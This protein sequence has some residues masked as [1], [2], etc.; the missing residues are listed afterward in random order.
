MW[1]EPT[2]IASNAGFPGGIAVRAGDSLELSLFVYVGT[3]SARIEAKLVDGMGTAGRI[4]G[5]TVIVHEAPVHP[6][7]VQ[8]RATL[9]VTMS[10]GS[11]GCRFQLTNSNSKSNNDKLEV[12]ST[13]VNR[14]K[15]GVTVVSLFPTETWM[16]RDNGLRRDVAGWLNESQPPFIRTPGGCDY[17]IPYYTRTLYIRWVLRRCT[18]SLY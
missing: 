18:H 3:G 16:G 14:A 11:D 2:A 7:W 4:L 5:S 6:Q 8:L 15:I 1:L 17:T 13:K 12:N 10:S 9:N